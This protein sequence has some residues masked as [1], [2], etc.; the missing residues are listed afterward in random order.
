MPC[1]NLL[2]IDSGAVVGAWTTFS[3]FSAVAVTLVSRAQYAWAAAHIGLHV[4]GSLLMAGTGIAL[5]RLLIGHHFQS[6]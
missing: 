5:A 6:G 3:T 4:A 2:A 1:L